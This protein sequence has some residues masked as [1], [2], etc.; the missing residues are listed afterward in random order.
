M[1]V[2]LI[3][4]R[5]LYIATRH[6]GHAP[7][8]TFK[9]F[10]NILR[11]VRE[12]SPQDQLPPPDWEGA[13]SGHHPADPTKSSARNASGVMWKLELRDFLTCTTWTGHAEVCL[14]RSSLEGDACR[15]TVVL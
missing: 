13:A 15:G 8:H 5:L 7:E 10:E 11:K 12:G 1:Y 6:W 14:T 9:Y 4:S 3:G 2:S